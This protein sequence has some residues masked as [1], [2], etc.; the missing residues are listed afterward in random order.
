MLYD[1]GNHGAPLPMPKLPVYQQPKTPPMNFRESL[2][3]RA[4]AARQPGIGEFSYPTYSTAPRE[5]T[6]FT[7]QAP[8]PMTPR[9]QIGF[10]N[11]APAQG[12]NQLKSRGRRSR[13]QQLYARDVNGR[14]PGMF[15]Y[16][17]PAAPAPRAD[18]VPYNYAPPQYQGNP[19]MPRVAY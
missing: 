9:P 12:I 2:V 19:F 17:P 8:A 5:Q 4:N 13:L 10:I 15:G 11:G 7:G 14:T 6:A 16:Q 18:M 1:N 3:K